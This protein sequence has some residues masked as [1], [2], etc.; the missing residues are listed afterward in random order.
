MR[1]VFALG[2]PA[3]FLLIHSCQSARTPEEVVRQWQSHIDKNEFQQ[4][5]ELSAPR[6]VQL[7]SWM[8]ALLADMDADS[9]ITH[10]E[11]LDL[12][13]REEG[14]RAVCYYALED[15]GELFRDSFILIRMKGKWLVDL[16]EEPALEDQGEMEELFDI[17]A[18][19]SL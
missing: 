9:V 8:E 4:A 19:D 10:T 5:K 18:P 16:P 12:S 13:C 11:L 1:F 3:A 15:E 14:D 2:L 17:M 7:L 6:T